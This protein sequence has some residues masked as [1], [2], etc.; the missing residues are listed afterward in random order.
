MSS[1]V[2]T[3]NL[4]EKDREPLTINPGA[5]L[6]GDFRQIEAFYQ[7]NR[8]PI[9][10]G[11]IG[12]CAV[13]ST[14]SEFL[15][16]HSIASQASRQSHDDISLHTLASATDDE[17]VTLNGALRDGNY[18]TALDSYA[19]LDG[20]AQQAMGEIPYL[21]GGKGFSITLAAEIQAGIWPN[22]QFDHK[23][24]EQLA[25]MKHPIWNVKRI[26]VE[27]VDMR[28][29]ITPQPDQDFLMLE[30]ARPIADIV[31]PRDKRTFHLAKV[32]LAAVYVPELGSDMRKHINSWRASQSVLSRHNSAENKTEAQRMSA[33]LSKGLGML[34]YDAS[35]TRG[36]GDQSIY[37]ESARLILRTPNK[38]NGRGRT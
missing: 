35:Q 25:R 10:A 19:K 26:E 20:R 17:L 9:F 27:P 11:A 21:A 5:S 8:N 31:S 23:I 14:L 33:V 28:Y 3:L 6:L 24:T 2:P 37:P 22:Q 16:V 29:E 36:F 38:C 34:F 13:C 30:R 7:E 4:S 12:S 32:S 1:K 18:A 15:E